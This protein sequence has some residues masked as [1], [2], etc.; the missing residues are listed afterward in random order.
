MSLSHF[1][2]VIDVKKFFFTHK[3]LSQEITTIENAGSERVK[4]YTAGIH[5]KGFKQYTAGV[6]EQGL[7]STQQVYTR[8]G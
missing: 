5:K 1:S 6:H 7:N 2:C 8:R 4:Q 3:T